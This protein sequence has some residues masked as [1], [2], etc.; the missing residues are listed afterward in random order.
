MLAITR[1]ATHVLTFV[2]PE[3][4]RTE[5]WRPYRTGDWAT[6]YERGRAYALE[7]IEWVSMTG[8]PLV[9]GSIMRAI[10]A[11]GIYGAVEAGFCQKVGIELIGIPPTLA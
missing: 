10:A 2:M 1:P 4:G 5:F 6:D 7:F 8:N 9:F 11:G 3:E